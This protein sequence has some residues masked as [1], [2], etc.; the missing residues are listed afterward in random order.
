M[1]AKIALQL[2]Q[3]NFETVAHNY[4]DVAKHIAHNELVTQRALLGAQHHYGEQVQAARAAKAV[5][6]MHA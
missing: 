1:Q 6:E 3:A 2:Q 5:G 4:E